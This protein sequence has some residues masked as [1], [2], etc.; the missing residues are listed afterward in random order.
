MFRKRV[1]RA[2]GDR[3]DRV[4]LQVDVAQDGRRDVVAPVPVTDGFVVELVVLARDHP[5]RPP[6]QALRPDRVD[7]EGRRGRKHGVGTRPPKVADE[8][9]QV[10]KLRRRLARKEDRL[11][12]SPE[13][14]AVRGKDIGPSR[15]FR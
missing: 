8:V 7:V 13:A 4:G 1:S 10:A 5:A 12:Q 2:I 15:E 11:G 3:H 6:C 9:G 14:I